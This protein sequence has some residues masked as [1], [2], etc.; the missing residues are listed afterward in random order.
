MENYNIIMGFLACLGIRELMACAC[1]TG[2][3]DFYDYGRKMVTIR[4]LFNVETRICKDAFGD[5]LLVNNG[6]GIE[7][8][9][10]VR[11]DVER[12]HSAAKHRASDAAGK[13]REEEMADKEYG[14]RMAL[15]LIS[16]DDQ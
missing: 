3:I 10:F 13:K 15:L 11:T 8:Y 2:K 1:P 5:A 6:L 12:R 9:P 14:A 7:K 4:G 16:Q